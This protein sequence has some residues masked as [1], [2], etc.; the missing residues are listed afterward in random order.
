MQYT[1]TIKN[2]VKIVYK[3]LEIIVKLF[4]RLIISKRLK[5]EQKDICMIQ[6]VFNNKSLIDF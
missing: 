6:T 3:L 4:H 2:V 5:K 1:K